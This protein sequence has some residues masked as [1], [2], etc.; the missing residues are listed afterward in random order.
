MSVFIIMVNVNAEA[1]PIYLAERILV[2]NITQ[3][4]FPQER[5]SDTSVLAEIALSKK[6]TCIRPYFQCMQYR[7]N[8]RQT[9]AVNI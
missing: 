5:R 4:Y 7:D 8:C 1:A 2:M 9:D 3:I 6:N